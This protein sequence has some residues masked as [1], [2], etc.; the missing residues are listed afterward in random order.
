MP[1]RRVAVTSPQTRLA[2]A[3]KRLRGRWRAPALDQADA[4][5]AQRLFRV[6]RRRA[7]VAVG[8]LFALVL[9]LPLVFALWP[10][11]DTVRLLGIPV[12]WL[13]VVLIPFPA[14]V[15]LAVWQL[16]RAEKPEDQE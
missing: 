4:E 9:L 7:M 6:Q 8:W 10:Q 13:M 5:R 11:L 1:H 14:M 3:R 16:R 2:H 15:F 12:S